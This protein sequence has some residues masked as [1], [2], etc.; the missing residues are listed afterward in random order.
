LDGGCGIK[1]RSD[2]QDD[3]N[4]GLDAKDRSSATE[5][6]DRMLQRSVRQIY[7][8]ELMK[9][10]ARKISRATKQ[11]LDEEYF[12]VKRWSFGGDLS[13][14]SWSVL[15]EMDDDYI[16]LQRWELAGFVSNFLNVL[17]YSG[18]PQRTA[19]FSKSQS[20]NK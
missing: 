17:Q 14:T 11:L 2:E 15:L 10:I 13:I 1:R 4:L 6:I 19:G 5:M 18:G 12:L 3:Q 20:D 16:L 8:Q 9:V 7:K